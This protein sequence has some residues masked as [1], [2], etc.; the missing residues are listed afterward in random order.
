MREHNRV[1]GIN[2]PSASTSLPLTCLTELRWHRPPGFISKQRFGDMSAPMVPIPKH[3]GWTTTAAGA[4]GLPRQ[5][6]WL[7]SV[8]QAGAWTKAGKRVFLS[9]WV[10]R[11]ELGAVCVVS[12]EFNILISDLITTVYFSSTTKPFCF[13]P[14]SRDLGAKLG[15][16]DLCGG[17][18]SFLVCKYEHLFFSHSST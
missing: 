14:H 7:T 18:T 1:V 9:R 17:C 4:A 10:F 13:L 8:R 2:L 3:L 15:G 5:W 12:Y 16:N 6:L 11:Y